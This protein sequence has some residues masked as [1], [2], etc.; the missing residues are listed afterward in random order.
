MPEEWHLKGHPRSRSRWYEGQTASGKVLE[1][2]LQEHY[3]ILSS[4]TKMLLPAL[5]YHNLV[6]VTVSLVVTSSLAGAEPPPKELISY[7]QS[8]K[9]LGLD[10]NAI[11]QNA[12]GAG[13]EVKLVD[14][15]LRS[16]ERGPAPVSTSNL[17]ADY[18]IGTGD[19]IQVSVWKEPDASQEVT[20]RSDGRVS[21]PLIKEVE[22]AGL[23]PAEAEKRLADKFEKMIM[24]A[25]VTLI[26]RTINSRKVY[27]VGAVRTVG[28]INM[29]SSLTVLQAI[30]QAGGLTDFAKKK[31]IYILRHDGGGKQVR[32]PFNYDA[33]IKGEQ[34]DHNI[35]LQ[36]DDTIVVPQ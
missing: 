9:E 25:D 23:T 12:R 27:L 6:I 8:A 29:T 34:M 20:V 11:R 15:A 10:E 4:R 32:L 28:A 22:I 7:I 14:E 36:P 26:V 31:N 21:L 35:L 1:A 17:P 16:S 18:R 2:K 24:G 5:I 33:V 19:V 13:W 30:A 3:L